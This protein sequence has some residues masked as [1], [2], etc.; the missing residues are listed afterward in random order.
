MPRFQVFNEKLEDLSISSPY[1]HMATF[2]SPLDKHVCDLPFVTVLQLP[3]HPKHRGGY[4]L[5]LFC[6]L[7]LLCCFLHHWLVPLI[8]DPQSLSVWV[9]IGN[10]HVELTLMA[11]T[12]VNTTYLK[13]NKQNPQFF[14]MKNFK[15]IQSRKNSVFKSREYIYIF[16]IYPSI[17][18]FENCHLSHSHNIFPYHSHQN[19]L[20]EIPAM[21]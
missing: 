20:K 1:S 6:P 3:T 15:H 18:T 12:Y 21:V 8:C 16:N 17:T 4:Q 11:I 5:P 19:I 14:I 7:H 9:K 13:F 10:T 2:S